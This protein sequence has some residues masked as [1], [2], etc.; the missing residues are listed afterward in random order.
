M[1]SWSFSFWS[2]SQ[3]VQEAGAHSPPGASLLP[4]R[5]MLQGQR[6]LKSEALEN[7]VG[8]LHIVFRKHLS[9]LWRVSL[10]HRMYFCSILQILGQGIRDCHV[11]LSIY[12]IWKVLWWVLMVYVKCCI[13]LIVTF[14][15]KAQYIQL[16][17]EQYQGWGANPPCS[18]KSTHNF[19]L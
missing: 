14:G 18:Q 7:V 5:V 16:T 9:A 8:F 1:V 17:L 4:C 13:P 19:W 6:A 10:E 2:Y 12:Y 3:C 15:K 11:R